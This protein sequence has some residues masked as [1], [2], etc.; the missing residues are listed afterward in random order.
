LAQAPLL[1]E[2]GY[3]DTSEHLNAD[4]S[5][6]IASSTQTVRP[7]PTKP[8][9]TRAHH[10]REP[11]TAPTPS[12]GFASEASYF[13]ATTPSQFL[14]EGSELE[15]MPQGPAPNEE[16]ATATTHETDTDH[17]DF[18]PVTP[19]T[20]LTSDESPQFAALPPRLHRFSLVKSGAAKKQSS[21]SVFG[22]RAPPI[23]VGGWSPLDLF[24]GSGW[25]LGARCDL[26]S[27]RLGW[28][29][30]LE[31]DDCGLKYAETL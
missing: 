12:S 7:S 31:C 27:K 1:S 23:I 26:C 20:A 10:Q 5:T 9:E 11:N 22:A 6:S 25:G 19:P 3:A 14:S 2:S 18:A 30:V 15:T 21:V 8:T 29:P 17:A 24:F 13:T 16:S 4:D 28:K